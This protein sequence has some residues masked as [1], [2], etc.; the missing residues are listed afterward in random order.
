[1]VCYPSL[2]GRRDQTLSPPTNLPMKKILR[3]VLI[4]GSLTGLASWSPL[5][6]ADSAPPTA[7]AVPPKPKLVNVNTATKTELI[8]LPGIGPVLADR[9]IA[10][11]PHKAVDDLKKIEGMGEKT[12]AQIKDL[13]TV[14]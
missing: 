4:I 12:F 2:C 3:L 9:I 13:V 10:G 14:E 5:A 1:M 6:A 11:R 8:K 7:P